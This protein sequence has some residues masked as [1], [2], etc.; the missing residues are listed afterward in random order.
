MFRTGENMK[1]KK[2]II[3]ILIFYF[4]LNINSKIYAK[5]VYEYTKTVAEIII[6]N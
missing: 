1:S 6:N 2:I 5:Y 3:S 4:M